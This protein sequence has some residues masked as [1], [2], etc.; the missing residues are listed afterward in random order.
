M[1]ALVLKRRERSPGESAKTLLDAFYPALLGPLL[2]LL[3]GNWYGILGLLHANG[4]L[5]EIQVPA[6]RYDFGEMDGETLVIEPGIKAG[7]VN[8]WGW[9]DLKQLNDPPPAPSETWR[10]DLGNWFFAARVIHDRG[11]TGKEDEAIDEN[12]A[13]S[14]LLGDLHPHVLSLP[15]VLLAVGLALQALVQGWEDEAVLQSWK[16]YTPAFL[17][18]AL[19]LGSLLALN[20]WDYPIYAFLVTACL[21]VGA[22]LR[23]GW[24]GLKSEFVR[25]LLGIALWLVLSLVFYLPF[26]LTFQSQAGGVLP[27]VFTPTRFRQFLV[28]FAPLI[29][30]VIFFLFAWQRRSR[31]FFS[32]R[33]A[34]LAGAG[35]LFFLAAFSALL[36]WAALQIEE[37]RPY[38]MNLLAPLQLRRALELVA[39]RRLLDSLTALLM[40]A[41]V[42]LAVGMLFGMIARRQPL[43]VSLQEPAC[44]MA[45]ILGGVGALLVL[46][47][48]FVFLRDNFWSRM[49]TL[50]KFYFQAWVLWALAGAFAAWYLWRLGSRR[51]RLGL[52]LAVGLPVL[53]GLTYL[54]AAMW[55]KTGGFSGSPTL[56]GMAYF[57]RQ[58]PADWAAVQW[59]NE[60]A[61]PGAVVVEGSRGAYW[62]E[63]RSS[64]I[65]M[66]TG[67][68]T[69]IGWANHESQWRGSYFTQVS[70][71]LDDLR[72]IYQSRDWENIQDLLDAYQVEYV[73]VSEL[74]R[75]WYRPLQETKFVQNM[76]VVLQAGDLTLY[77]RR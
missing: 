49:N 56:D 17:L 72:T 16:R 29:G 58:Y 12:P 71:R 1:V 33:A 60:N 55:S 3:V 65:S 15:F 32:S 63:G 54:P 74:E 37:L 61:A 50:F 73:V 42:G 13:F 38:I 20:T 31:G 34:W 9:L 28:M 62:V 7:L 53:L 10:I 24:R 46:G 59:L 35:L 19:V 77:R 25:W 47:P 40:A 45:L 64:R 43:P 5:A 30:A 48:E 4:R 36:A 18:S 22:G 70:H 39:Q 11:L 51:L 14:F 27:N 8:F 67:L 69:L 2:V 26:F 21:L 52:G 23:S 44:W 41:M 68:P 57:V 6:I 75:E 66:A 76:R